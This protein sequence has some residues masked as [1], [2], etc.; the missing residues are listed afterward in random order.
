LNMKLSVFFGIL[1]V[2]STAT[3]ESQRVLDLEWPDFAMFITEGFA[4]TDDRVSASVAKIDAGLEGMKKLMDQA[5]ELQHTLNVKARQ[6]QLH[7]L[8]LR[9]TALRNVEDKEVTDMNNLAAQQANQ[10]LDE[11][12]A[13]IPA[14]VIGHPAIQQ[15][16]SSLDDVKSLVRTATGATNEEIEH[17]IDEVDAETKQKFKVHQ[18][19]VNQLSD[20]QKEALD[21]LEK[22]GG[23]KA[24]VE[25]LKAL[26]KEALESDSAA[27]IR[28]SVQ[29]P[30]GNSAVDKLQ[31]MI[32]SMH[33]S[34][35]AQNKLAAAEQDEAQETLDGMYESMN[36]VFLA[37]N[38]LKTKIAAS[39]QHLQSTQ[40][41]VG[42]MKETVKQ[43]QA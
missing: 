30:T 5:S 14:S 21:S 38:Q 9:T 11:E 29:Q 10:E 35:A 19:T 27:A 28:A 17:A 12:V 15:L 42:Q 3:A 33:D 16:E 8:N 1:A 31:E 23:G 32:D 37:L 6:N 4:Q 22:A 24:R 25:K 20:A 39:R 41:I 2:A 18:L 7:D 43:A 36:Q 26:A 40:A 13:E 34:D